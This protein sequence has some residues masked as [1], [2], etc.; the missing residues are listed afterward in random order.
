LTHRPRLL[1]IFTALDETG[2]KTYRNLP[3][4][5]KLKSYVNPK[6]LRIYALRIHSNLY[7]MTGF[8]LKYAAEMKDYKQGKEQIKRLFEVDDH[9]RYAI[10]N[11][12]Y[13]DYKLYFTG[14]SI[15]LPT[16]P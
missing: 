3:Q 2:I 1:D 11:D 15:T 5:D 4:A 10:L 12:L 14:K 16:T 8:S 7:V 6:V 9:L 13:A